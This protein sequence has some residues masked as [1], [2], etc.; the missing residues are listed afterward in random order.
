MP[1]LWDWLAQDLRYAWRMMIARPG[2]TAV[3]LLSIALG[4]G[5][6]TAIFSV[7]Y[8]VLVDPYPYRAAD[9]IG[10]VGLKTEKDQD[11]WRISYAM[12]QY[13]EIRQRVRSVEDEVALSPKQV[14]LTGAN[15][16]PEIVRQED[17]S[18]NMFEFYGVPPL[19]GRAFLPHDFPPG[20]AP[21]QVA[22]ISYK[23][24]QHAF[25]GDRGVIGRKVLLD[26]KEYTIIGVLPVRF[27]WN[28]I[29]AYTPMNLR[30]SLQDYVQIFYRIRPGVTQEQF[31]AE[32]DPIVQEFRKQVPR[33]FFPEGR[34]RLQWVSVNEGI[35]GKFA[36]TLLVLF[37]AVFLLLLI[38]CGNV[39]NLLLA[40]AA[41]RDGEMAIRVSI[42]ATRA[43]LM[44]QMLTESVL[45]ALSGGLF[46]VLLAFL[47]IKAVVALMPEYSIPHEAV[48]AINWP[49][50]W[51][52]AGVS[53]LTGIVFGL[54]PAL[55][56]SAKDQAEVLKG[57]G[58]GAGAGVR[59]RRFHDALMIFEI[60]L[61][62]LLLTGAGL[63]VKGLIS[64]QQ[65]RLGYDP[66]GVLTFE[67]PLGEGKYMQWAGRRNLYQRIID[68]FGHL[69]GVISASIS[70][71]GTPPWNGVRTNLLLDDRPAADAVPGR[72]NLVSEGYFAT[73][74]QPLLRGRVLN[75]ADIMRATP[76]AVISEDFA[77]RYFANKDPIGR[78]V[79]A[80]VLNEKLP[81]QFLKAPAFTNSFEIVGVVGTVV[82]SGLDREPD[83]AIFVPYSLLCSPGN[84]IL[85]RTKS[86]PMA[87]ANE[88]RQVVKSVDEHEPITEV[89]PLEY[90]LQF[91]TAYPRFATFLFGVFGAVGMLLAAAGVFS[92]V[93]YGVAHRTREFGIRMAL[94]A[95]PGDVLRLVLLATGRILAIG[96]MVGLAL[97]IFAARALSGRMQGMG[98]NDASL[99]LLIL[100]VLI[101]T[102]LIACFLPAR[103]ATLV[104]PMDALRH[105]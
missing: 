16:L 55:Q 34:S 54:A 60:T 14:I 40:R 46:G 77:K 2:F 31:R 48:I 41:A 78:H 104:Q 95:K 73:V 37:G 38:A 26:D 74:R 70:E 8:A 24:W 93:S 50:L 35:L 105:E 99:F 62:L 5:A 18:P 20:Q 97:S 30:P 66:G 10:W 92:V 76:V 49:V 103:T 42:G 23:F 94:G 28:D 102:T 11:L 82:N 64:L 19:F 83:P 3:A 87:F 32:F 91:A 90:W 65:R 47:G 12:A 52:A 101:V 27:T 43:R 58:R 29:D 63:A 71:V 86:D 4:I 69:P 85:I 21:E 39:A 15:I 33:Y 45:L 89:H 59:N 44:R 61:S 9:R 80:Q 1:S 13:I 22:V 67:L 98:T 53:V 17:C 36:T 7:V 57:T 96:L 88:A 72:L 75:Y 79:Q 51:F 56:V 84:F 68:R 6:T 25:H 81:R 100:L